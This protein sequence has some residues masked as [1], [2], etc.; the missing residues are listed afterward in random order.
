MEPFRQKRFLYGTVKHL[1]VECS[2]DNDQMLIFPKINKMII[3][4]GYK[5]GRNSLGVVFLYFWF[6]QYMFLLAFLFFSF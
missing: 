5:I 1:Y 2:V 6:K 4:A 3:K